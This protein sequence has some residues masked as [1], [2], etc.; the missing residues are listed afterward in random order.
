MKKCKNY[1][2][3]IQ[4][5]FLT[6]CQLTTKYSY[7][8]CYYTKT[9]LR[10]LYNEIRYGWFSH[11]RRWWTGT[12]TFGILGAS[13]VVQWWRV[14]VFTVA[15]VSVPVWGIST[16]CEV[17][18]KKEKKKKNNS[19]SWQWPQFLWNAWVYQCMSF[20]CLLLIDVNV[21][22]GKI[23]MNIINGFQFILM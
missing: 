1:W 23:L 20:L 3:K 21:I 16:C 5:K 4:L 10:R 15:W 2:Q 17:Q 9:S 12:N 8:T 19:E 7:S 18:S 6:G 14:W 11:M 22:E 13:L